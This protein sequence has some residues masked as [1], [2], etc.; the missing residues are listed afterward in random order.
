MH[1]FTTKFRKNLEICKQFVGNNVNEKENVP[2]CSVVP[3]F[4]DLEVEALS[5]TA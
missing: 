1:N 5:I 4:S 2:R 3:T